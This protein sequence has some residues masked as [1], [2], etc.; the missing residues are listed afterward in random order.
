MAGAACGR[1]GSAWIMVHPSSGDSRNI[2][3]A[4]ASSRVP[5]SAGQV[6]V[7]ASVVRAEV[8]GEPLGQLVAE[9]SIVEVRAFGLRSLK[10]VLVSSS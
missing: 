1:P 6:V 8:P 10:G 9:C 2:R 4:F 7:Q 5:A 3:T